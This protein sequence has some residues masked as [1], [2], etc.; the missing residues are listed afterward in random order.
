MT[1]QAAPSEKKI[2]DLEER[3]LFVSR[4]PVVQRTILTNRLFDIH[5][6]G[7]L[8]TAVGRT[9]YGGPVVDLRTVTV[10]AVKLTNGGGS[11]AEFKCP[12][13]AHYMFRDKFMP[14]VAIHAYELKDV[15]LSFDVT[16]NF[17]MEFYLFTADG[18][19]IN[20]LF[21]GAKPFLETVFETVEV[22]AILI[23]DFFV[24]PNICHF[25]FD[26][27]PRWMM[28]QPDFGRRLPLM[29]HEFGYAQAIFESLGQEIGFLAR[30]ERLRGTVAIKNLVFFSDSTSF[31]NHPAGIG[32]PEHRDAIET[33]VASLRP[34]KAAVGHRRVMLRRAPHLVRN[35]TNRIAF[36]R[37]VDAHGF[38]FHDAAGMSVADQIALFADTAVLMGVHG[39]GLANLAFQP[40]G[41]RIIELMPPMCGTR[42]YWIMSQALNKRYECIVC[43]DPYLGRI[44]QSRMVHDR[45]NN[46]R[47]LVVPL[48]ELEAL[49]VHLT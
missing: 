37:L 29:F 17:K 23:D 42:A 2:A 44:D 21:F 47:D 10:D 33:V 1:C 48:A 36:E 8:Q 35:I 20:G 46:R 3:F 32:G 25:L 30:G 11:M 9:P 49:L 27:L 28:A 22:P 7:A 26:K 12:D 14:R 43:D 40:A 45:R 16:Y 6:I 24:N 38:E 31:L 39:A 15:L 5:K 13:V 4:E 41:S 18:A 34:E 19:L